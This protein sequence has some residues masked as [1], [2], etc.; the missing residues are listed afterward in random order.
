MRHKIECVNV[1]KP[2]PCNIGKLAT[3]PKQLRNK[4]EKVTAKSDPFQ[5]LPCRCNVY[6]C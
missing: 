6:T 4:E 2:R 3:D 5:R 1:K